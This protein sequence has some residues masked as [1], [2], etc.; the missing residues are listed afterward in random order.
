MTDDPQDPS[1]MRLVFRM[2]N[3]QRI[4]TVLSR[5]QIENLFLGLGAWLELRTRTPGQTDG[6][7]RTPH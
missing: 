5:E 1:V 7:E 2:Q 4:A 6:P 3:G